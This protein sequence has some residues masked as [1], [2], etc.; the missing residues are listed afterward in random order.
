L[1]RD[2]WRNIRLEMTGNFASSMV[3]RLLRI[4]SGL[5][6]LFKHVRG[7]R[8]APSTVDQVIRYG[9]DLQQ[10]LAFLSAEAEQA[11][12]STGLVLK[13]TI[14]Q[15]DDV[16]FPSALDFQSNDGAIFHTWYWAA[17]IM[18]EVC[19]MTIYQRHADSPWRTNLTANAAARKICMSYE[20]AAALK[21]LGAQFLQLPLICAHFVSDD[22]VKE[23]IVRK[24]NSL[25]AELHIQYTSE[26]V[27]GMANAI[28]EI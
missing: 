5:P 1:L 10:E 18:V 28:L 25:V 17:T 4:F 3:D 7:I 2:G 24:L 16:Q 27:Q 23:W 19:M 9:E 13:P 8:T 14:S 6:T 22:E 26:Y 21:P 11:N 20:Y 12:S 15:S